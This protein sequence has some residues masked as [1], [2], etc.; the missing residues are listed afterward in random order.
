MHEIFGVIGLWIRTTPLH[1][2]TDPCPDPLH[3]QFFHFSVI[4]R[5]EVLGVKYELEELQMNVY[6]ILE[7]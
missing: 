3:D 4:E 1:F 2:G 7:G 5:W 6:D